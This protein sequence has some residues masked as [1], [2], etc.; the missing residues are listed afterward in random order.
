MTNENRKRKQLIININSAQVQEADFYFRLS[1]EKNTENQQKK[2]LDFVM[3][4]FILANSCYLV[5]ILTLTTHAK[6]FQITTLMKMS[7]KERSA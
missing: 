4:M 7:L 6:T 2:T 1:R 3:S 5:V